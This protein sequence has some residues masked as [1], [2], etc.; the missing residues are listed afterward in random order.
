MEI[1]N[2]LSDFKQDIINNMTTQL[3]NMQAQKKHDEA[4]TI[5]AE[6]YPHCR[7]KKHD[8]KC[9]MVDNLEAKQLPIEFKIVESDDDQVFFIGQRRPWTQRQGMPQVL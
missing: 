2:L 7:Q 1:T 9:K 8:C 6:L 5:L 3:D 4:E